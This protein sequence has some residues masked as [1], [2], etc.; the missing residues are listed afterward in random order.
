MVSDHGFNT[1]EKIY[2][3]G[4]S[5]VKLLG[6]RPGG[7]HHVI[8]KRR[9]ML[10]Y[11]IKGIYF[12]VPLITTTTDD[13][14]YLKGQSTSYPTVL[15]D[16]DGNERASLHLRDNDLN[17][18]HILL[19]QLQQNKL[20]EPLRRAA[21]DSF[22]RPWAEPRMAIDSQRTKRELGRCASELRSKESFGR[23]NRK[24]YA[25]GGGTGLRRSEKARLC[26]TGKVDQPG[27]ELYRICSHL[28]EFAGTP[29]GQFHPRQTQN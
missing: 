11:A 23:R 21:T 14:Y 20:S 4:Y 25:P 8:T 15:A 12:M 17:L 26:A 3:Q 29:K 27:E 24:V 22:L 16:F 2:S 28:D 6:S 9:L 10:D 13:S 1:D 19:Q 5:L 7:G 18:L